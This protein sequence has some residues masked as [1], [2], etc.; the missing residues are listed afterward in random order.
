M[1]RADYLSKYL[2]KDVKKKKKRSKDKQSSNIV[3]EENFLEVN[4][5]EDEPEDESS[6]QVVSGTPVKENKGFKRIDNGEQRSTESVVVPASDDTQDATSQQ[7]TVYRDRSGNIVDIDTKRL[8]L[9]LEKEHEQERKREAEQ[10][11]NRGDLQKIEEAEHSARL[12]NSKSFLVS[13][14]DEEYNAHMKA[15]EHFDDPLQSFKTQKQTVAT[16]K[17]GKMYYNK[18]VSPPNRF[19]IR[20]GFFWDGIDRSNGFE[21]LMVRKRN[22]ISYSKHQGSEVYDLDLEGDLD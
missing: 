13:N 17:T 9:Q 6:A 4:D 8:Q 15:K 10:S 1:S 7:H 16:S 12:A 3:V 5:F 22:E 21:D 18:G 19:N 11:I 20:A 14:K 2:S